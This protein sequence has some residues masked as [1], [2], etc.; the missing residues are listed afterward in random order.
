MSKTPIFNSL[1]CFI[2]FSE[3]KFGKFGQV[4]LKLVDI[5]GVHMRHMSL[6]LIKVLVARSW[7]DSKVCWANI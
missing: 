1:E 5:E 2:V 6:S 3:F 7:L 4:F